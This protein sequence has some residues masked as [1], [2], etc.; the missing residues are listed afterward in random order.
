M[1][2]TQT[3]ISIGRKHYRH[4]D[5]IEIRYSH[6]NWMWELVGGINDGLMFKTLKVAK[7]Y[8]GCEG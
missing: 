8:S 3:W 1:T 6:N 5:G 4:S 7:Y 2:A